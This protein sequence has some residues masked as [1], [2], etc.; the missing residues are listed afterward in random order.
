M[1]DLSKKISKLFFLLFL[2][3]S[4]TSFAQETKSITTIKVGCI[5][6]SITSGSR[7]KEDVAYPALLGKLL[8]EVYDVRNFG[9]SGRTLLRNGDYPYWKEKKYQDALEFN[10]DIVIIKLGTNDSKPQN[11]R[12][13]NEFEKDYCDLIESFLSLNSHPKIF[14]CKPVPAFKV[15]WGI[16]DSI[17]VNDIL[18]IIEKISKEKGVEIIDLY[19]ALTGKENLF[20]DAI[21]PN[22]EGAAMIA[23]EIYEAIISR[24]TE[25]K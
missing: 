21:H 3:F 19:K 12:Y 24:T 15:M 13:K 2:S 10:P 23:K 7:G 11:W 14:I 20:P 4:F 17:I 1:N 6:N 9:V 5:G 25:N 22:E 16:R 18:S 8:G